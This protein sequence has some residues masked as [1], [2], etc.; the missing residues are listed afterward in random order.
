MKPRGRHLLPGHGAAGHRRRRRRF[1]FPPRAKQNN[2]IA[3][4]SSEIIS[5]LVFFLNGLDAVIFSRCLAHTKHSKIRRFFYFLQR[6]DRPI[7]FKCFYSNIF[8]STQIPRQ[9]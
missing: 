6:T 5:V 2:C 9:N 8:F 7:E 1:S 4:N 3:L